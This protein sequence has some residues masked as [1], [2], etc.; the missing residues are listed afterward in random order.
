MKVDSF[1]E[2]PEI[3]RKHEVGC[4]NLQNTAPD[5]ILGQNIRVEKNQFVPQQPED[6]IEGH[7]A[8][9][10]LVDSDTGTV[11]GGEGEEDEEGQKK[12]D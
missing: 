8:E 9:H 10:V 5:W 4:E 7:G 3:C 12:C 1:A 11:E 2:H 6:V